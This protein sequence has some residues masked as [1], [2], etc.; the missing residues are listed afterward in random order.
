MSDYQPPVPSR[1]NDRVRD[2]LTALRVDAESCGLSDAASVR[3]RGQ[4]RT[5]HQ[6]LAGVGAA[7]VAVVAVVTGSTLLGGQAGANHPIP[8]AT[9]SP[10]PHA[11]QLAPEPLLLGPDVGVV[12]PYQ[13]FQRNPD[14]VDEQQRPMQCIPNPTALGAVE[15]K[16]ALF[17]VDTGDA[18]FIEH[19][20]RFGDAAT[21]GEA[22]TALSTSFA[23]C[24]RGKAN[25]VSVDDRGPVHM[26]GPKG[27]DGVSESLNASRLTTPK[28]AGDLGYYELGVARSAN[29]VVVLEWTSQ[30]KPMADKHAWVWSADRLTKATTRATS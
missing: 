17:Y 20:L 12:G 5:R 19:V 16:A 11:L 1:G 21:A 10:S 27:A 14:P 15:G 29:V 30:G 7:V 28:T 18:T 25:E 6:A 22:V 24:D 9:Q 26:E 8:P 3:R 2:T 4:A 23:T 13:D